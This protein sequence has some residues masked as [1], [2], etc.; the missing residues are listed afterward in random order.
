MTIYNILLKRIRQLN[1]KNNHLEVRTP[2]LWKSELFEISGHLDH[3]ANNMFAAS[4]VEDNLKEYF[5]KPMNCPGHMEVFRSKQWSYRDLPI[6]FAEYSPLHRNEI[7][8]AIGGLTRC[9]CFCQDDAHVFCSPETLQ[10]E[11]KKILLMI[12]EVYG[13]WFG[14][15]FRPVLS[16]RP[17]KFMGE[18]RVWETAEKALE[19]ALKE[20]EFQF[21][22]SPGDGAFYGPKIDFIVKDSLGREWQ[23][24]TIQ[25]DFQ[26]PERF[27][28]EYTN[29]ENQP[30][31]P[32][33]I[34]R[35]IFGSFERF[36]GILLESFQ[37][38]LPFWLSPVS[39]IVLPI[40]DK[41]IEY[42]KEINEKLL[43]IGVRSELDESNN[44][45]SQKIAIDLDRKIP[46]LV[47][48]GEKEKVNQSVTLKQS[49]K[50][51][52]ML[53]EDFLP[54]MACLEADCDSQIYQHHPHRQEQDRF[55]GNQQTVQS[56][57]F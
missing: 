56:L 31:R 41:V 12:K 28:L 19:N 13:N 46:Y 52:T 35:A 17:E 9:R 45:L 4:S 1:E 27:G 33:V 51:E 30:Q 18:I 42:A 37:G 34:H 26:L 11:I 48:V 5:I 44:I 47:I 22:V 6:G 57:H 38:K 21:D 7:S 16:T 24:A 32:I 3:Y 10:A 50:Q 29:K 2:I 20:N 43:F 49:G 14:M 36:I 8:G 54:K 55:R 39:V 25:L 40:S 15:E 23:T 53:L